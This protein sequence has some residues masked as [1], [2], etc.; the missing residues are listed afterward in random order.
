MGRLSI[1]PGVASRA[2]GFDRTLRIYEPDQYFWDDQ[3]PFGLVLMHD[4]QNLF[5]HPE[6]WSHPSWAAEHALQ[7]LLNDGRI[8][9]W[10]IVGV[11][12]GM[13][14]FEDFSP[15]PEPRAGVKGRAGSYAKFLIDEL[16]P[17]L[18]KRYRLREGPQWTATVGSS[19]GGLVSLW[20]HWS[21]PDVFG[22]VGALSPSV[23]WCMDGLFKH[24]T[25]HT[26]RWTK[27]YL[28][29]GETEVLERPV[30]TM[31]YGEAVRAFAEHLEK[32]GYGPHELAVFLEPG[33]IHSEA[34]W[35]RR[36]PE[37]LAWVLQEV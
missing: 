23:M 27:L 26:R 22:R 34:D 20:L 30:F 13:G 4:A 5:D 21:R 16:I 25:R 19:L 10:L 18:R 15:W 11:D 31:R 2:E 8:G 3:T 7:G 35:R 29:A 37:A 6:T 32:L 24:W 33:G 28:D 14:R 17:E 9:P 36:L 1:I 12:H